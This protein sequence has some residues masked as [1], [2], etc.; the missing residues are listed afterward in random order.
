MKT[1]KAESPRFSEEKRQEFRK[2]LKPRV[3]TH[4]YL[5]AIETTEEYVHLKDAIN[6]G[7]VTKKDIKKFA[8][9]GVKKVERGQWSQM[10][11]PFSVLACV[12]KDIDKQFADEYLESLADLNSAELSGASR[13]A[14]HCLD[15]KQNN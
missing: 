10:N 14:S 7:K 15:L 3:P 1:S 12:L 8:K 11:V 13:M 4:A 2:K 6:N 5:D 9:S